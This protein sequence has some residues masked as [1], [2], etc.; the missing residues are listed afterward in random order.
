MGGIAPARAQTACV[1]PSPRVSSSSSKELPPRS[2]AILAEMSV[3]STAT[4]ATEA[5]AMPTP[6]S[7]SDGSA[8]I[9]AT[10]GGLKSC[11]ESSP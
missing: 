1:T 10:L 3:S 11:G 9:S 5:H 8:L 2:A 6:A 7:C 4:A